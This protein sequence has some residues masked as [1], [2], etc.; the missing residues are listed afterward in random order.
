VEHFMQP[1]TELLQEVLDAHGGLERWRAARTIRAAVRSGGLLLRMRMPGNRLADYRLQM[2]VAEPRIVFEPFP[3]KGQRGVFDD[4]RV[5]IETD[6]G[7]VV[8]SRDDPRPLFFGRPGVRRNLRWDAC[9]ATYFAGYAMWNY[10]TTPLLLT[11][12][13]MQVEEGGT[14][15]EAGEEWRCLRVE[16]PSDLDTHSR[17][18]MFYVNESGLLRRQDYTPEVVSGAARAAHYM[19]Q[20][21]E[22]GGLVFPTKRRVVPRGPGNRSL[23]L[24][25]L[26][27]LAIDDIE[28]A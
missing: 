5:R 14:W 12:D 16:F 10:L 25:V 18:Q 23:R 15:R 27:W 13:G 1:L 19:E 21:R 24:P 9:D 2:E 28:V 6:G 3:K 26:V 8:A 11:R 17:R 22:F 20:H 4:G 7:E